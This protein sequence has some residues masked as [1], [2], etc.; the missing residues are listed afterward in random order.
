MA[1]AF[2]LLSRGEFASENGEVADMTVV[3][4]GAALFALC[5][6]SLRTFSDQ[7]QFDA[8]HCPKMANFFAIDGTMDMIRAGL[9]PALMGYL[10]DRD[11]S[12]PWLVACALCGF[13]AL[14]MLTLKHAENAD[15][16]LR[17]TMDGEWWTF[18]SE[19]KLRMPTAEEGQAFGNAL[20]LLLA[21]KGINFA[22]EREDCLKFIDRVT[23]TV[24]F[25]VS[26]DPKKFKGW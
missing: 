2:L 18:V 14:L 26:N 16:H 21:Q 11:E 6:P 5:Q 24:D 3:Y 15:G 4:I 1:V 8:F 23:P 10:Y 19:S 9:V 22:D 25:S 7:I 20:V 13:G 12:V 17:E